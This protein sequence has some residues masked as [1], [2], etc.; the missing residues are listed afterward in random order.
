MQRRQPPQQ[1]ADPEHELVRQRHRRQGSG[2]VICKRSI[3][4]G[5]A[6]GMAGAF[7]RSLFCHLER[8]EEL[9]Q[10]SRLLF[11]PS[12]YHSSVVMIWFWLYSRMPSSADLRP[13]PLCLRP[14]YEA[15]PLMASTPWRLTQTWPASILRATARPRSTSLLQTDAPKP[16]SVLLARV[17]ASSRSL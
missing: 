14:P 13:R 2:Q 1:R 9:S 15:R 6:D 17:I 10:A 8:G 5:S 12:R 11:A 3:S 16:N 7:P 4:R